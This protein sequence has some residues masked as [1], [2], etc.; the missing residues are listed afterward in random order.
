[1]NLVQMLKGEMETERLL[2]RHWR[3]EE[4]AAFSRFYRDPL[5]MNPAGVKQADSTFEA[6]KAFRTA[7]RSEDVFAIVLKT[8]GEPIGQIKFQFDQYRPRVNSLSIGYEL[9]RD[10][11]GRGYMTEA[12]RAMVACGFERRRADVLTVS[13]FVGNDRSRRVIEKCGFRCDG[14]LRRAY[15]RF[16]G[17]VLDHVC[18]SMLR[19]EYLALSRLSPN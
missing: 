7:L 16:D 9:R 14:T 12:L 15:R 1:M 3:R 11:W 18:Y 13:H 8:T 19:E 5:V 10:M 6:E 2:L 17:A 4:L